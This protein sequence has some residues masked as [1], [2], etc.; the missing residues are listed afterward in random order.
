ML[1]K[2]HQEFRQF[3]VN[4]YTFFDEIQGLYNSFRQHL[5]THHDQR[6]AASRAFEQGIDWKMHISDRPHHDMPILGNLE[7]KTTEVTIETWDN[8]CDSVEAIIREGQSAC[9]CRWTTSMFFLDYLEFPL[10]DSIAQAPSLKL[11]L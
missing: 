7:A 10:L 11:H 6:K 5:E 4:I 9:E 8:I 2:V 3:M 1:C